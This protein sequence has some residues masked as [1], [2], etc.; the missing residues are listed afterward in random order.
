M[1]SGF[2]GDQEAVVGDS[3]GNALPLCLLAFALGAIPFGFVAGK[4]RGKDLREHGSKNIGATNTLRVLGK[5]PGIAVLILDALKGFA[6]VLL[7]KRTGLP[8]SWVVVVGLCAVLGHI[9]SPFVRFKGGKG[10]AT[11]LGV[12]I[13]LSPLVAGLSFVAFL[14]TVLLTRWVSLGSIIGAITEAALFFALPPAYLD[15]DPVPYRVFG[16]VVAAFVIFRHRENIRRILAGTESRFGARKEE[17]RRPKSDGP[18][19]R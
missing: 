18:D 6:P 4:L 9:Y 1:S 13:G 2:G 7:A 3:F 19:R 16:A 5:G 10:V 15:G 8:S 14:L 12:L 17:E 11:S